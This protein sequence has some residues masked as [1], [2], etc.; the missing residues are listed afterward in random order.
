MTCAVFIKSHKTTYF[1]A[2]NSLPSSEERRRRD[3]KDREKF[4]PKGKVE[5]NLSPCNTGAAS[6][7][8][9][10]RGG[11]TQTKGSP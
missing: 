1:I 7:G 8:W 5:L 11:S 10:W 6:A 9:R 4:Q 2:I 3:F